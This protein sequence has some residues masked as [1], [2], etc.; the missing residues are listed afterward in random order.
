[1][2]LQQ[3]ISWCRI[4][5]PSKIQTPD[6]VA[7]EKE[8]TNLGHASEPTAV[9]ENERLATMTPAD[10]LEWRQDG[11]PPFAEA[12]SD[13]DGAHGRFVRFPAGFSSPAHI[14]THDYHGIVVT[15]VMDNPMGGGDDAVDLPAGSAYF[16]P[17]K[18]VHKT[19]CVSDTPCLFCIHQ[20]AAF[21]L[22]VQE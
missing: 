9:T 17:G 15:G 3:Y 2:L 4:A 19:R 16:V 22:I 14:H 18:T 1:M 10:T 7:H 6:G 13:K 21:D 8:P 20:K 12:W 11:G 5:R